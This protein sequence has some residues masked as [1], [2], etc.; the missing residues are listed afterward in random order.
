MKIDLSG[1]VVTMHEGRC[2]LEVPFR[3]RGAGLNPSNK[4]PTSRPD[5]QDMGRVFWNTSWK[6]TTI[7]QGSRMWRQN[8]LTNSESGMFFAFC[9][10]RSRIL[11]CRI[12]FLALVLT[13]ANSNMAENTMNIHIAIQMSIACKVEENII[14][15]LVENRCNCNALS[16]Y[17]A[18]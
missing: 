8:E 7:Y 18:N 16:T 4:R 6:I 9:F 5:E 17:F 15:S 2:E 12:S 11:C 14:Y 3:G 13:M 1:F 10:S